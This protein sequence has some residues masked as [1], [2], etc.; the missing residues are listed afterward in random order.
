VP[1]G[2][3]LRT[4]PFSR[5]SAI[6]SASSPSFSAVA[7]SPYLHFRGSLR[8]PKGRRCGFFDRDLDSYLHGEVTLGVSET[9]LLIYF[10]L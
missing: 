8:R 6:A 3:T 1:A 5:S 7:S 9:L 4:R 2:T 10:S